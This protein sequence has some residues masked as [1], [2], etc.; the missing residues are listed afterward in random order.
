MNKQKK[1]YFDI[2]FEA[3][4]LLGLMAVIFKLLLSYTQYVTIYPPLA[5]LDDDLM[6]KA[7]QSISQGTWLG[8]YNYLTIS[9]HLFFSLW[10]AFLHAFKIPY[11]VGN[12]A[13]WALASL[14]LTAAFSPVIKR[15]WAKL[16]LFCGL[17]YNPATSAQFSTRIY[18]DSIFPAL[19]VFFFAGLI[20]VAFRHKKPLKALLPWLFLY[21]TAFGCIYLCREDGLWLASFGVVAITITGFLMLKA[22]QEKAKENGKPLSFAKKYQNPS[23]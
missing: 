13:L 16:F 14:A 1:S 7:A 15:N 20:A 8:A 2:S 23:A 19:C 10:L 17:L 3:M 18:R 9:K 6:F 12:M 21:G 22:S 11:L 4:L 5:P